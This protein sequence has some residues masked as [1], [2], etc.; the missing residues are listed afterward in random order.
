LNASFLALMAAACLVL[1]ACHLPRR[2]AMYESVILS[3][4]ITR[5]MVYLLI[6]K[7]ATK[8]ASVS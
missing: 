4:A 1:A 5:G 3:R 6:G 8:A 2:A 7:A